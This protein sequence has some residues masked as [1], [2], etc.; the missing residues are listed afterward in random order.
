MDIE[1]TI[2]TESVLSDKIRVL[3]KSFMHFAAHVIAHVI[4]HVVAR[5]V[6]H[7]IACD[8]KSDDICVT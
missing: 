8:T 3:T 6:A 1:E 5:V 2:N 4:A 7:V